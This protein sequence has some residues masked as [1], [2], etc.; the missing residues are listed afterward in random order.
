MRILLITV[1]MLLATCSQASAQLV[2]TRPMENSNFDL[3][4]DVYV[5]DDIAIGETS[6]LLKLFSS[7]A[8]RERRNENHDSEFCQIESDYVFHLKALGR[9]QM[10]AADPASEQAIKAEIEEW[11]LENCERLAALVDRDKLLIAVQRENVEYFDR[12]NNDWNLFDPTYLSNARLTD[13]LKLA[14]KQERQLADKHKRIAELQEGL[15]DEFAPAFDELADQALTDINDVLNSDQQKQFMELIGKPINWA[16]TIETSKRFG[17][18]F[19]SSDPNSRLK[20]RNKTLE[21]K[22]PPDDNAKLPKVDL[23]L[24]ELLSTK[25]LRNELELSADQSQKLTG[26]LQTY[27]QQRIIDES[28]S[29]DRF[30]A[31]VQAE[32]I[33]P[34]EITD[35]LLPH[36]EDCLKQIELQF[37]TGAYRFSFG[38]LHPYLVE[39]L[40]LTKQQQSRIKK[41]SRRFTGE[42]FAFSEEARTQ[43]AQLMRAEH[44]NTMSILTQNQLTRYSLLTGRDISNIQPR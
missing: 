42:L 6:V 11:Q 27:R 4:R 14:P 24:F 41:V 16:R 36:Q 19:N 15:W 13:T 32:A 18:V 29:V 38:L 7:V 12:Y 28:N 43:F 8:H 40:D 31:L 10:S 33:Y 17:Y 26:V 44:L 34:K 20:S 22:N 37:R 30:T 9:K 39:E 21:P 5:S 3:V 25:F 2:V 23:F 1:A 35:L